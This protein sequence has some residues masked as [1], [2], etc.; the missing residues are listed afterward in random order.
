VA[1]RP[2]QFAEKYSVNIEWLI[3]GKGRIAKTHA[4]P[5]TEAPRPA[6]SPPLVEVPVTHITVVD[7][8]IGYPGRVLENTLRGNRYCSLNLGG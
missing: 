8:G 2:S 7:F 4:D 6:R 5:G 1:A 3:T